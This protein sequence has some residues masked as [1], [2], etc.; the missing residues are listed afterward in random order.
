VKSLAQSKRERLRDEYGMV[1]DYTDPNLSPEMQNDFLDYILEFERQFE[2]AGATTVRERIGNPS[3]DE[4]PVA[5]VAEA[6]D[7]LLELLYA[8]GIIV[9]FLGE[10]SDLAAYRYLTEELLDEETWEVR[11][12]DTFSCFCAST[13]EYDA[14][15]WAE[16]FAQDLFRQSCEDF[17][18]S[19]E[20]QPLFDS[21]GRPITLD[22]FARKLD[23]VWA[24]LPAETAIAFDP[25]ETEVSEEEARV[26]AH[27]RWRQGGERKETRTTFRLQPSPYTGWDVVQTSLLD[28]VLASFS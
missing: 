6:V 1:A 3:I 2:N 16:N 27:I 5:N 9:D 15:M 22:A 24:L 26:L 20:K 11:I 4:L 21:D 7:T 17:L 14:Q 13:P 18:A 19:L 23:E 28:D 10:W 8:H 12:K 25:Q